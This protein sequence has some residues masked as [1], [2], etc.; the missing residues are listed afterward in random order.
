MTA[1]E[2]ILENMFGTDL[3]D[4]ESVVLAF[5]ELKCKELL[6]IVA[7][8]MGNGSWYVNEYRVLENFNLKEFIK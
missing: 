6:E 3:S 5:S 7:E 4:I 1:E 2:Y 8:D